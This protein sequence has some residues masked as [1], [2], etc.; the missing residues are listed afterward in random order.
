MS[1]DPWKSVHYKRVCP[2]HRRRNY[3][4]SFACK[5]NFETR[6]FIPHLHSKW[7][8]YMDHFITTHP[9]L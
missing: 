5:F 4:G 3:S 2:V 1:S 9:V 7:S 6:G 8:I